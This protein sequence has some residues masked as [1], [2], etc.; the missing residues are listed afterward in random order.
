MRLA[1]DGYDIAL[2]D[3]SDCCRT[4]GKIRE[5][6]RSAWKICVNPSDRAEIRE[7]ICAML[8]KSLSPSDLGESLT[9]YL[10]FAGGSLQVAIE[11]RAALEPVMARLAADR[12]GDAALA[13]LRLTIVGIRTGL[14]NRSKFF[15]MNRLVHETK[16]EAT[17]GVIFSAFNASLE[18]SQTVL[19]APYATRRGDTQPSLIPTSACSLLRRRVTAAQPSRRCTRACRLRKGTGIGGFRSSYRLP[20]AGSRE[21]GAGPPT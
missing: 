6:G 19:R 21:R 17:G 20:S 1:E 18:P 3:M 9:L 12:I 7:L 5:T 16:V 15:K 4:I 2:V 11:A 14:N 13:T 8:A 10:Q